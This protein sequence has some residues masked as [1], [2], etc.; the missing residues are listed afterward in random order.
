MPRAEVGGPNASE[1]ALASAAHDAD[2]TLGRGNPDSA[3]S[4]GLAATQSRRHVQPVLRVQQRRTGGVLIETLGRL[5]CGTWRAVA[6]VRGRNRRD[7]RPVEPIRRWLRGPLDRSE[8][9]V[10][11][12]CRG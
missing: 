8:R 10:G 3:S 6:F 12:L 9:P 1:R 7:G 5:P 4:G 2:N 11:S